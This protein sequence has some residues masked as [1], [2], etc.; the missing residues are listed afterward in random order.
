M[1]LTRWGNSANWEETNPKVSMAPPKKSKGIIDQIFNHYT[2]MPH[3]FNFEKSVKEKISEKI[4]RQF[5]MG[6]ESM[7]V[8]W[9]LKKGAVIPLHFHENEQITW[10]TEGKAEV[11]SQGRK[12]I[13][14]A[15]EVIV[16]PPLVPHEFLALEDTIDIDIFAPVRMDWLTNKAEYLK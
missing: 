9:I 7:L 11:H 2:A 6:G 14:K 12:F 16:F 5:V 13:V 1:K 10:I 15:G 3:F 4:A 8:K